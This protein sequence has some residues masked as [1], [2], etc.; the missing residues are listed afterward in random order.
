MKIFLSKNIKDLIFQRDL[1]CRAN[2][3]NTEVTIK[4]TR[5]TKKFCFYKASIPNNCWKEWNIYLIRKPQLVNI[6]EKY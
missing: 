3:Q 6:S 4:M 1:S 5:L 2:Q